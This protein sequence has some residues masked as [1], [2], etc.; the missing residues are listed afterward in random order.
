MISALKFF[1]KN[2]G[3]LGLTVGSI[4]VILLL[5]RLHAFENLDLKAIDFAFRIRGPLSGWMARN[6]IPKDSLDVVLV[7]IDDETY[8]LVPWTWPYPREVW[9]QV[10]RNLS[11]AGAKVIVFD[12]QLDAPESR[13]EHLKGIRRE[14]A[15]RGM[16]DLVPAHGDSILARAIEEVQARG[17]DVV[18][19]SKIVDET[20]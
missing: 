5:H 7:D 1:K 6:E 16:S 17:T 20:T 18:I 4:L 12:I 19:A 3:G 11:R 2:L 9:A 13:S 14:L 10:V 15:R 8:R